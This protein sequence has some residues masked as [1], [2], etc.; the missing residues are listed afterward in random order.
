[1]KNETK[2]SHHRSGNHRNDNPVDQ[3]VSPASWFFKLSN[4]IHTLL[5]FRKPHGNW[6]HLILS[7]SFKSFFRHTL[8]KEKSLMNPWIFWLEVAAVVVLLY[9]VVLLVDKIYMA[10]TGKSK[11]FEK[12]E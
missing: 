3:T 7:V 5:D 8:K 4:G 12:E 1:L 6:Q 10:A 2:Q 11:L 9:F